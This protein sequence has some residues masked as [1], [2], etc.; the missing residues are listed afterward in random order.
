MT[1]KREQ[2]MRNAV[3]S[4]RMEGLSISKQTE[5]D[6]V[7]YLEGQIDTATL[8]REVLARQRGQDRPTRR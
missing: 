6:C 5:R 8:V 2:A 3:A 1:T 7:R 4:T